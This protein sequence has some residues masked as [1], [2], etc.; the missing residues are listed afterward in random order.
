MYYNL[1]NMSYKINKILLY[2]IVLIVYLNTI[3]LQYTELNNRSSEIDHTIEELKTISKQMLLC[4]S[5]ILKMN[6]QI[7]SLENHQK[8]TKA[9]IKD[10]IEMLGQYLEKM[11]NI[12]KTIEASKLMISKV[13]SNLQEL[14][15]PVGSTVDDVKNMILSYDVS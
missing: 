10:R 9:M 8:K 11:K 7:L 3:I 5:D 1:I 2:I 4:E 14:N 15:R 12:S 13:Q 6:D